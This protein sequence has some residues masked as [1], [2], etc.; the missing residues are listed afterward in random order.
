MGTNETPEPES[1]ENNE[2]AK[3]SA[4]FAGYSAEPEPTGETPPARATPPYGY[5]YWYGT[6]PNSEPGPGT[7][8]ATGPGPGPVPEAPQQR[9][10]RPGAIAAAVVAAAL[11]AG[12]GGGFIGHAIGAPGSSTG[13][14]LI[15]DST[16]SSNSGGGSSGTG[17]SSS[18]STPQGGSAQG[19][20]PSAIAAS[21]DPGLV[22]V[23]TV[24]DYGRAEGA[25]TGIV[26]TSSGL[27]LTNNHVIDGATTI[28]VTDVGNGRTYNASVVGYDITKD[29]ALLKLDGASGLPT[30]K[31]GDSSKVTNGERVVGIGN[32]GG[33]GGTPSYAAGTVTGTNRSL[34]ASDAL[35]GTSEQ[36]NGMISTDA[37]IRAGDSGGPLVNTAGQ[38][39][40]I[41]TAGTST[42]QVA[43]A[44][45]TEGFAVPINT[46][47]AV[48]RQIENGSGSGTV[49]VGPTAF[50]GVQITPSGSGGFGPFGGD[51]G[52]SAVNG[53]AISGVVAGDP[54]ANAGLSAGDVI[55]AVGGH[56][57]TSSKALQQV[58]VIDERPGA[59]VSV[60]YVDSSGVQHTVTLQLASGPPA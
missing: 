10:A 19:A 32:A 55:T 29:V 38:V 59:R 45:S 52:S 11:L 15:G 17:G 44:S 58:L 8:P 3:G 16:P 36:L 60:Q 27:I 13:N 18:T 49:H 12:V 1:T 47:M 51:G 46:A 9:R 56:T 54:A 25:G 30:V 6:P 5:G 37:N 41:D 53:A 22:D 42:F 35:T 34:T 4:D 57:V 50:L 48:V 33:V 21:V 14:A 28:R 43:S 7:G 23:N 39:I 2:P 31:L 20:T 40:G 24:I 26:L